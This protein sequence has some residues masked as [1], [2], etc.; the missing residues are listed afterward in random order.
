MRV[1]SGRGE[2]ERASAQRSQISR[3]PRNQQGPGWGAG[4]RRVQRN[5]AR[6]VEC[7]C[8]ATSGRCGGDDFGPGAGAASASG[9]EGGA[10]A[11]G[12]A[13]P[14]FKKIVWAAG[15]GT[16]RGA[17]RPAGRRTRASRDEAVNRASTAEQQ[18]TRRIRR[19]ALIPA[20]QG[21]PRARR[22]LQ[23]LTNVRP[24]ERP[25]RKLKHRQR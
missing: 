13:G 18:G 9:E 15:C 22:C 16:D 3:A 4:S 6:A 8:T 17:A 14:V 1:T 7:V 2:G 23:C 11:R 19:G 10:K 5:R 21:L 12:T 25:P 24:S 20:D